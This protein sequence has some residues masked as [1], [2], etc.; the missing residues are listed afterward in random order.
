MNIHDLFEAHCADVLDMDADL[1][2]V[3]R[4]TNGSYSHPRFASAFRMFKAGFDANQGPE[5]QLIGY[6]EPSGLE[7]LS[8][9]F[10]ATVSKDQYSA[11]YASAYVK[12][13]DV[14]KNGENHE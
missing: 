8:I 2:K 5:M 9:G 10:P 12:H 1:I 6:L 4:L 14:L 11:A 13:S 3:R 7:R